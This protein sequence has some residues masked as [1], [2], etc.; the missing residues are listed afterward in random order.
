[1]TASTM[2]ATCGSWERSTYIWKQTY[3]YTC[4][5]GE[6]KGRIEIELSQV[7]RINPSP[8]Q[9][10]AAVSPCRAWRS[11]PPP[12]PL[13]PAP[14]SPAPPPPPR[15]RRCRRPRPTTLG[16]G[17]GMGS[18]AHQSSI[19]A[20]EAAF[21][22]AAHSMVASKRT[23]APSWKKRRQMAAPMPA[24]PPAIGGVCVRGTRGRQPRSASVK[25]IRTER[26][27]NNHDQPT[28]LSRAPPCPGSA[29]AGAGSSS[30]PSLLLPSSVVA[31][32][33]DVCALCVCACGCG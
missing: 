20:L 32:V 13:P 11:P 7:H 1:M 10:L 27:C 15:P 8:M 9:L 14:Q 33:V 5:G 26:S 19:V 2:A 29:A 23:L 31:P 6:G 18:V 12:S 25:T 30:T 17:G 28:H 4:L 16:S 22:A 21:A 24:A 3:T